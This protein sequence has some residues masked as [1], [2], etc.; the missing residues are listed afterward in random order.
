MIL[1][2]T[3]ACSGGETVIPTKHKYTSAPVNGDRFQNLEPF[4]EK[5]FFTLLK[6]RLF[7]SR[8]KWPKWIETPTTIPEKKVVGEE[9]NFTVI[10]HATVLIQYQGLNILT[11]PHYSERSSPISWTG[12]KRVRNPAIKFEDL[13]P[14]DVVLISHNHYDHLD[15]PT[16]QRLRDHSNPKI[17]VGLKNGELL[18]ENEL[19]NFE[20]MDW[21]QGV[22]IG[23]LKF[24]FVPA[25]HW[26]ARGLSDRF[27]TLWGG[28][29]IRG[30]KKSVYFAGDTGYG[31]F[32]SMISEKLGPP[33]LS[34]IPIGAYEPR[35]FMKDSHINPKE[36]VIAHH[37][38]GSRF[39]VGIHFETFQLTDEDFDAPRKEFK[40][41]WD[42]SPRRGYFIAPEFGTPYT[43]FDPEV[44]K[45]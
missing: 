39:S 18:K 29:Y 10:N 4:P 22:H 13:P 44:S 27:Q 3:S 17:F 45:D 33:D 32:F 30:P 9:L 25:Q 11:D 7:G 37:E 21:W 42:K 20:E 1:F 2:F 8:G 31:K 24:I 41:A 40:A 26:S 6:W 23:P 16:L 19:T 36:A 14:I 12:P 34:F 28:F 15:I 35:W 43:W 5:S 38:L